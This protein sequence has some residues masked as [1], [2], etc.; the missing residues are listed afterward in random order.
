MESFCIESLKINQSTDY[1]VVFNSLDPFCSS[2]YLPTLG[3]FC[4]SK[5]FK[6]S[7][8]YILTCTV[9]VPYFVSDPFA[10]VFGNETFGGGFADFSSLAKVRIFT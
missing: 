6:I 7:I 4:S 1:I 2:L 9:C 8:L 5:I 3:L 10:A